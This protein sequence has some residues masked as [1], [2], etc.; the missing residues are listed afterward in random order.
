MV[1]FLSTAEVSRLRCECQGPCMRHEE[2]KADC[3]G[4]CLLLHA[5]RTVDNGDPDD[6]PA[7]DVASARAVGAEI[8]CG[9]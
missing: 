9:F 5:V 3:F 8:E 1:A 2:G 7:P 4:T 6:P